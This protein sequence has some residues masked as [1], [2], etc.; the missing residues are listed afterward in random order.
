MQVVAKEAVTP[1]HFTMSPSGVVHVTPAAPATPSDPPFAAEFTP[2]AAWLR[3]MSAYNA[4]RQLRVFKLHLSR[5]MFCAWRAAAHAAVFARART[6]VEAKAFC[7]SSAFVGLLGDAAR[8]IG[9]AA[10]VPLMP[11][12]PATEVC[13]RLWHLFLLFFV[14]LF[15]FFQAIF[16]CLGGQLALALCAASTETC[17]C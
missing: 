1:E 14:R 4:M 16:I 11:F 5:K 9:D 8:L 12:K 2:L 17:A 7:A 3:E 6:A 15:F 10:A 13:K